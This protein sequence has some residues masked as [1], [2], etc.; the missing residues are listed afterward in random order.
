MHSLL[1]FSSTLC[2]VNHYEN[3]FLL[4]PLSILPQF[5][6]LQLAVT[7][8]LLQIINNIMSHS[9]TQATL[10]TEATSFSSALHIAIREKKNSRA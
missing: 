10:R 7:T 4:I 5:L 8:N 9:W 3:F 2:I 6:Q 1:F